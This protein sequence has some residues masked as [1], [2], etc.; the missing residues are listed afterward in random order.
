M[1]RVCTNGMT[2][3]QDAMRV[4]HVSAGKNV[5]TIT[6]SETT[7]RKHLDLITSKCTD[8]VKHFM[9]PAYLREFIDGISEQAA[10]KIAVGSHRKLRILI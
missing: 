3:T 1:I 4:V 2:A 7:N 9:T 6:W 8:A 5:G 10:V